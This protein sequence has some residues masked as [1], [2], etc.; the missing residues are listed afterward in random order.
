MT[1]T[2][3]VGKGRVETMDAAAFDAM[4]ERATRVAVD[5]G[6]GDAHFAYGLAGAHPEW[7]VVGVDALDEPMGEVAHK[8]ARKPARGGRS[9]LLLLRASVESLPAELQGVA[10]EITVWLPWGHLLEGIVL[11]EAG[12]MGGLARLG[13]S[14]ARLSITLNGEIWADSTPARYAQLP[15][16]DP[17]YVADVIAPGFARVDVVV[18]EPARWLN[19]TEASSLATTW[20]RRLGHGRAHPKFVAFTGVVGTGE[21]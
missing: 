7:L 19:A 20:A 4:S 3:V 14:G 16:P 5:V 12:V 1:L 15:L 6:T 11:A 13:R 9:N 18:D 21:P 8:A 17:A 10:D 2:R